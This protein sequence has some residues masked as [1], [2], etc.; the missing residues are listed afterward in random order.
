VFAS[1]M[2]N[3]IVFGEVL[4]KVRILPSFIG[5]HMAAAVDVRPDDWQQNSGSGA[6]DVEGSRAAAF[7][8]ALNQGH[9]RMLVGK[10]TTHRHILLLAD[11]GFVNLDRHA[12]ATHWGK[13]A[14]RHRGA[15]AMLHEPPGLLVDAKH[16][17]HLV[18]GHTLLAGRH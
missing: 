7:R 1:A 12:F 16:A 9:Y 14:A 13:I 4:S 17:V 6:G 3:E 18:R 5:H 15:D 8:A 2:H 11:E 10:A